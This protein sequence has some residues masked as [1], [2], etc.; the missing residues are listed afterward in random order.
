[1]SRTPAVETYYE[2]GKWHNRVQNRLEPYT[3]HDTKEEAEELG[4]LV[5]IELKCEHIVKTKDGKIEK[6]NS[7][8][9]DPYP[10]RG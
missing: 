8:G 7:Y 6:R 10:P 9:N 1:M 2:E 5:A 4:R 3:T